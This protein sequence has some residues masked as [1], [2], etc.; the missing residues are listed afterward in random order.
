MLADAA[1]A[2]A[3]R[4][5]W[6]RSLLAAGATMGKTHEVGI[7]FST[8]RSR[9]SLVMITSASRLSIVAPSSPRIAAGYRAG[10]SGD[11]GATVGGGSRMCQVVVLPMSQRERSPRARC[12]AVPAPGRLLALPMTTTRITARPSGR[13]VSL[14]G[15]QQGTCHSLSCPACAAPPRSICPALIAPPPGASRR[16]RVAT[17]VRGD[18]LTLTSAFAAGSASPLALARSP[19]FSCAHP[20]GEQDSRRDGRTCAAFELT[21]SPAAPACR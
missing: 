7:S 6:R 20:P 12:R 17:T 10:A 15:V 16:T 21:G 2:T 1:R 14:A 11:S 4:E 13:S 5:S 8:G 9:R 19:P 18:D 3:L